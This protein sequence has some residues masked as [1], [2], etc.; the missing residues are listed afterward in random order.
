MPSFSYPNFPETRRL[1]LN[2][3]KGLVVSALDLGF[4]QVRLTCASSPTI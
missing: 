1:Y 3:L 4:G 2:D